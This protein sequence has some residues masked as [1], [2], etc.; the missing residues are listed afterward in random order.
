MKNL[1]QFIAALAAKG[2][3]M[4]VGVEVDPNLEIPEIAGFDVLPYYGNREES[5]VGIALFRQF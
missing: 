5:A 1:K 3:L 4:R 2:E